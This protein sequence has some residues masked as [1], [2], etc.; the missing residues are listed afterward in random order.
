MTDAIISAGASFA[1]SLANLFS[2][3]HQANKAF[4]RQKE[5]MRIQNQYAIDNWNRENNY[6]TPS[7]QMQ[8]L[9]D[10]GLNPN[11][12]YG[13]GSGSLQAGSIDTPSA[14]SA[15]MAVSPDFSKS[16]MDGANAA[17]AIAQAKKA[18]SETIAQ[19]IE[20]EY[21]QKTLEDRINKVSLENNWTK[22]QTKKAKEETAYLQEQF[23]E[24]VARIN[25]L[26]IRNE[27]DSKTL[28]NWDREFNNRMREMDDRHAMSYEE[29][30]RLSSTFD[31]FVRLCKF[32]ADG[33][34]LTNQG[35]EWSNKLLQQ[36]WEFNSSYQDI[37]NSLGLFG[38]L[39]NILV[40][41]VKLGK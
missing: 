26:K 24:L 32:Q 36:T 17:L 31:D 20:N 16:I 21:N 7:A 12:V 13:Q 41:I 28:D 1:G 23:G 27:I 8:R 37:N 22:E 3:Q 14:P 4:E 10:A 18:G 35:T 39:I 5:L 6:N 2:G 25:S 11:L 34:D 15:P 38:K 19:N 33:A 30:R 40:S 29:R 9:R